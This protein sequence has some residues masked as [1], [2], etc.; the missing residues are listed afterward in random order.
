[1]DHGPTST[2]RVPG[3]GAVVR[4]AP[5]E[6]GEPGTSVSV[7][8]CVYRTDR[9]GPVHD[10]VSS[11]LAQTHQ[12]LVLRIFVDGPVAGDLRAC[13]EALCDARV[14]VRL[15]R[16]NHGLAAGLNQLIDDSLREGAR[17]IAR[18]DADDR[19]Y[20]ERLERQL[21]FLHRH[22]DVGVLGGGCVEIDEDTGEEFVKILPTDDRTLKRELV[23]RT[24]F[25]HPTVV[26]RSEVFAGGTRYRSSE[27]EDRGPW[28]T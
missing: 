6:R 22:P 5:A 12:D 25:V 3:P 1:M 27:S 7:I 16:A 4:S 24:P 28:R 15:S 11:I 26:F 10:A 2:E 21:A 23:K 13:L 19:S 18:M 17:F 8:M 14:Q 20:P 9:S